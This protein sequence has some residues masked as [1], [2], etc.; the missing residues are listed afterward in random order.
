MVLH[1][2]N[3]YKELAD[4]ARKLAAELNVGQLIKMFDECI[5]VLQGLL[6]L[7]HK[8]G[9][10][11]MQTR[12][13][14]LLSMVKGVRDQ[15]NRKL[16]EVLE[17][18]QSYLNKLGA[19]LDKEAEMNYRTNAVN[20]HSFKRP[21]LDAEVAR[22]KVERP[23]WVDVRAEAAYD[24]AKLPKIPIGHPNVKTGKGPLEESYKSFHDLTPIELPPGTVLYRVVDP[25]S[26]DNSTHWMSKIEFDKLKSKDDWR[27]KFAVFTTWNSN[28]E[29]VTYTVPRGQPLKVWEGIAASQALRDTAGNPISAGEGGKK[30]FLEGGYRQ[31]VVDPADLEKPFM[32]KRQPTGWGYSGPGETPNLVGV[33]DLKNNWF[34]PKK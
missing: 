26:G 34:E 24:P 29:F 31:I 4:V 9:N 5:E 15:A 32:S 20:V 8:W 7:V 1:W 6:A 13:G 14:A 3:V 25:N 22:F 16:A 18:V 2:D 27:R 33:P 10:A 21:L 23:G 30:F 12:V 19:R 28:G 11:A 17:P